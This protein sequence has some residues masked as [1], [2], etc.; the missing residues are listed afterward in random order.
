MKCLAIRLG[1]FWIVAVLAGCT[2]GA[3]SGNAPALGELQAMGPYIPACILFCRVELATT[4]SEGV[5]VSGDLSGS[6]TGGQL[7]QSSA[8]QASM[9]GG[10][11]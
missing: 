9:T 5:K 6:I 7:D 1:L 2:P 10:T 11:P 3:F 4:T 8:D